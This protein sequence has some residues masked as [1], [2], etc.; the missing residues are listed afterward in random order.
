MEKNIDI[1]ENDAK[2]Y[3]VVKIGSEQYGI[4][5]SYIDNI[6]RMQKITRV[7][8][9]QTYFK[10]VIN[11]RGEIVPVMSVRKKMNLDDDVITN[12]SRIIILKLEEK[13]TIGIIVDEVKEV[14]TLCTDEIDKTS[15]SKDGKAMFIN[16]VGKHGD[17]LISLF[18]ISSIIEEKENA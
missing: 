18:E 9:I 14:V 5:I 11:L 2:Q 4:D 13:G 3:I 15:G 7:P 1:A 8:K 12:A 10:G 16:G 6:V 17:E